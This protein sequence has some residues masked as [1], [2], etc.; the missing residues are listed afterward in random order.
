[1][2]DLEAEILITSGAFIGLHLAD[3]LLDEF[4]ASWHS[5][6]ATVITK[7]VVGWTGNPWRAMWRCSWLRVFMGNRHDVD[8]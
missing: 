1:M 5:C 2:G 7:R 6:S 3:G 4:L 8:L